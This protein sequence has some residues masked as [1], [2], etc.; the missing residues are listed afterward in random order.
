MDFAWPL[1]KTWGGYLNPFQRHCTDC[2]QCGGS[3][4]SVTAKLLRDRWYGNAPF[5]PEERGSVPFTPAHPAVIAFAERNVHNS[6][7]F[8]GA[9]EAVV[10]REAVRLCALWNGSWGH[11][12]NADDVAALLA[13]NRLWDLTRT[14]LTDEQREV[15]RLKV[16]G[17]GNSWLPESNGHVP[18]PEEVNDWSI[19]GF[20]HDSSNCHIVIKAEC[21]R[22]GLPYVCELCG[23]D[24]TMWISQEARRQAEEWTNVEPPAGE[25]YQL[26]ETTSEGSPQSPVFAT[27]GE[28]CEWAALNATTFGSHRANAEEWRKML[29]GLVCHKEGGN[30]FL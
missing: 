18:T 7:A 24:G 22:L 10:F 13:E 12:L 5:A 4:Y 1:N 29:G 6:T 27:L 25:G 11:H 8:Y 19:S 14:P 9:G 21:R 30:I 26:W 15:V 23:G 3:G 20:G 17:G 16:A 2:P 28:V